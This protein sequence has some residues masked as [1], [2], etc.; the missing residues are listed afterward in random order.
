MLSSKNRVFFYIFLVK[1]TV[2]FNKK[3]CSFSCKKLQLYNV[4][5]TVVL[6]VNI[7]VVFSKKDRSFSSKYYRSFLVKKTV[8]LAVNIT[9]VF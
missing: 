4:K 9:V 1:N 8:V 5:K 3:D 2:L 7:T 6:A